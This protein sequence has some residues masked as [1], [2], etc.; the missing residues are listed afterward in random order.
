MLFA[1][2]YQNL[3]LK[4]KVW[5][6]VWQILSSVLWCLSVSFKSVVVLSPPLYF[7]VLIIKCFIGII[8]NIG[9]NKCY[10]KKR[11]YSHNHIKNLLN[12][13]LPYYWLNKKYFKLCQNSR[14]LLSEKSINLQEPFKLFFIGGFFWKVLL[15]KLDKSFGM[16]KILCN[17]TLKMGCC[18]EAAYK[19]K[20]IK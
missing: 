10:S 7:S 6:Y 5:I 8:F 11:Y 14:L 4:K 13:I 15:T 18:T 9:P 20:V 1:H 12:F 17:L 19:R 2:F 16:F 3:N